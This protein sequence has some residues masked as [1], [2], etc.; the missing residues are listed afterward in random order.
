MAKAYMVR[1]YKVELTDEEI[2]QNVHALEQERDRYAD[3]TG[4]GP[5]RYKKTLTDIIDAYNEA[6]EQ[7]KLAP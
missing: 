2:K 5:E 1:V 6:I 4:P 3:R 7:G